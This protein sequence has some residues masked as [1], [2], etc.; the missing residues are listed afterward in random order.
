MLCPAPGCGRI[1]VACPVRPRVSPAA[2][3]IAA[4]LA[5]HIGK[6]LTA[7]VLAAASG[8]SERTIY[9]LKAKQRAAGV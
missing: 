7:S 8:L 4:A 5:C 3:K 9:A 6:P 1:F 2:Q